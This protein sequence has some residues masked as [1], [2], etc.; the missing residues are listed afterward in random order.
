[1][2]KQIYGQAKPPVVAMLIAVIVIT[3]I[4]KLF[5]I[6]ADR[7]G[8][9]IIRG[10]LQ[11]GQLFIPGMP[12][13]PG[14]GNVL[15]ERFPVKKL[16]RVHTAPSGNCG[17]GGVAGR[18][19]AR[20]MQGVLG[21]LVKIQHWETVGRIGFTW[22]IAMTIRVLRTLLMVRQIILIRG[23][24]FILPEACGR[25]AFNPIHSILPK[26]VAALLTTPPARSTIT[27]SSSIFLRLMI[28][29]RVIQIKMQ[30]LLCWTSLPSKI[31]NPETIGQSYP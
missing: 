8:I 19:A 17:P 11:I 3:M 31:L 20:L 26:M 14:N 24:I 9:L 23:V 7:V 25:I 12:D 15:M 13:T 21:T 27:I 1:M 28:R 22:I 6:A 29:L 2:R 5:L 30:S 18:Q 16:S 4:A 10:R